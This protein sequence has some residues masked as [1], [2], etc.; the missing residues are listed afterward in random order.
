MGEAVLTFL[1]LLIA[2]AFTAAIIGTCVFWLFFLYGEAKDA[3][4]LPWIQQ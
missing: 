4:L 2:L 1:A 3:G